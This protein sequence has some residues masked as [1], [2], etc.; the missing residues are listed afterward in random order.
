MVKQW[1]ATPP[2]CQREGQVEMGAREPS[3]FR[4]DDLFRAQQ[5][6]TISSYT[7]LN[8]EEGKVNDEDSD[9]TDDDIAAAGSGESMCMG[10][11]LKV[12]ICFSLIAMV[13]VSVVSVIASLGLAQIPFISSVPTT[14]ASASELAAA[15]LLKDHT[16]EFG[17][18]ANTMRAT[19]ARRLTD[20]YVQLRFSKDVTGMQHLFAEDIQLH[21]DVSKA[22]MLV[23][24]KIRSLLRFQSHLAGRDGVVNFYRAL[25]AEPGDEQPPSESFQCVGDACVV[26][27]TVHRPVVGSIMDIATL[28]WDPKDDLLKR[29]ELSFCAQ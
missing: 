15:A 27:A 11:P 21:V 6:N 8:G 3:P 1:L 20:K 23:G 16:G 13:A 2:P 7:R 25:P 9:A 10:W 26:S 22:G 24:M 5:C 17:G 19:R 18:A 14:H 4:R 29:M 28:H 12:L